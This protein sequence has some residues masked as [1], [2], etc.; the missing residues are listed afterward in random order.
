MGGLELKVA[1]GKFQGPVLIQGPVAMTKCK[2]AAWKRLSKGMM[3]ITEP[4][5]PQAIVAGKTPKGILSM[6]VTSSPE[7][8]IQGLVET[9]SP[10]SPP[11]RVAV[12]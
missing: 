9:L 12:S 4:K 10:G 7:R 6:S 3:A 11:E 8:P 5:G 2:C 1:H